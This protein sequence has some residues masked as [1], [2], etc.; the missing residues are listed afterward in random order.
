[1]FQVL[2]VQLRVCQE[3]FTA[4][5]IRD[6]TVF[7]Y[8]VVWYEA[9]LTVALG[10]EVRSCLLLSIRASRGKWAQHLRVQLWQSADTQGQRLVHKRSL[11]IIHLQGGCSFT[12]Q[13]QDLIPG[14]QTWQ[15]NKSEN[16][17]KNKKQICSNPYGK[18]E[19]LKKSNHFIFSRHSICVSLMFKKKKITQTQLHGHVVSAALWDSLY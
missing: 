12:I 14:I 7:V 13:Q 11:Q 6:C 16:C 2:K 8:I 18:S 17:K 19:L 10:V 3:S 4:V 5:P 15:E 9:S 1:M